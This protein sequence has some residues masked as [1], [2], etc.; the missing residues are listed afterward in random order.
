M[1]ILNKNRLLMQ[2]VFVL[3]ARKMQAKCLLINYKIQ[4]GA[5]TEWSADASVGYILSKAVCINCSM[6]G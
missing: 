2:P 3:R 5:L 6:A 4:A 1:F